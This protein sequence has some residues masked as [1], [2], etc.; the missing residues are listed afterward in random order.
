METV[1]C[2]NARPFLASLNLDNCGQ[3]SDHVSL[4]GKQVHPETTIR[5]RVYPQD[6]LHHLKMHSQT[7]QQSIRIS[8]PSIKK[9][10]KAQHSNSTVKK[11]GTPTGNTTVRISTGI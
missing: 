10:R 6:R 3:D 2:P 1:C 9:L 5:K 11:T 7:R 8:L 4:W